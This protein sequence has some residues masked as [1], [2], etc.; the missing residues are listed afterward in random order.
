[1]K[2][3][4]EIGGI[5]EHAKRLWCRKHIAEKGKGE[6]AFLCDTLHRALFLCISLPIWC[7]HHLAQTFLSTASSIS[8]YNFVQAVD[9]QWN[10]SPKIQSAH[11]NVSFSCR[12][13]CREEM[14]R[15]QQQQ[16]AN[17]LRGK[18]TLHGF[19]GSLQTRL[20]FSPENGTTPPQ[21]RVVASLYASYI[22]DQ[23]M[24]RLCSLWLNCGVTSNHLRTFVTPLFV[25]TTTLSKVAH[26][27]KNRIYFIMYSLAFVCDAKY[28]VTFC[29]AVSLF[30]CTLHISGQRITK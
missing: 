27:R 16:S 26:S 10:D 12:E 6:H 7:R 21:W 1:M 3:H 24:H 4:C 19:T 20:N 30:S 15:L 28:C 13:K 9:C 29:T 11:L 17:G 2:I 5:W 25:F 18:L 22:S 23:N 8:C 14:R